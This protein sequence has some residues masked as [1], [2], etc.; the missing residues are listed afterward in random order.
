MSSENKEIRELS[1]ALYG[2]PFSSFNF[3]SLLLENLSK[4]GFTK[5]TIIQDLFLPIALKGFDIIVKAKRGS[6]KALGYILVILNI[7]LR[8]KESGRNI[9]A[10]VLVTSVE[11]ALGLAEMAKKLSQGFNLIITPF[12][13]EEK[14]PE[15]QLRAL[16][17]G[18][19]VIF[20]VPY[21]LSR[22]IKWKLIPLNEI[23]IIVLDELETMIAK[24]RGLIENIL[25]KLPHQKSRQGMVFMEE[26]N[27]NA[28]EIAYEFLNNPEEIF[29]EKGRE[30]FSH[31]PLKLIHVSEEE[32][33]S[34]LLGVL[35]RY[36][37]PKTI[38]FV[39]NK[40]EAQKLCDELKKLGCRAVFLKPDLGP[41]YRLRFLK[42]FAGDQADILVATDAGCRFIQQKGVPLLI[43]YDLP[44]LVDDFRNRAI[45]VAENSGEIISF[46]DETGAFFLETLE[47]EL[48]QK[49][50]VIWPEP[51]E[52]WFLS[53]VLIKDELSSLTRKKISISKG[54]KIQPVHRTNISK[55]TKHHHKS[56]VS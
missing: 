55:K 49:M 46:C 50:E 19:N 16:D 54:R 2:R 17:S 10:L 39:N 15:E 45:K 33:F 12:A 42:Q 30:D 47:K 27:Y 21:W 56:I 32:K 14:L 53:P 6:G 9:R 22:A 23:K 29:I 51:E 11:R 25:R 43:N 37:W 3:H 20:T 26:L 4:L 38:I 36:G 40:L 28:L 35:K 31:I 1:V 34:L 24:E 7:I 41:E 8:E 52:E 48:G 18:A 13:A 44:E 5:T